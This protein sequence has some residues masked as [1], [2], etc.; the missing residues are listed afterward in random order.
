MSSNT[1]TACGNNLWYLV[2]CQP[3][4]ETYAA[5]SLRHILKLL[6]FLPESRVRSHGITRYSPFF[7]GYL[8]IN[9]DLQ[10]IPKSRINTCPG[11]LRLVEFGDS[12]QSIPQHVIDTISQQLSRL[13]GLQSQPTHNFSPGDIVQVKYGPLQDLEMIF[14]GS[15]TPGGRVCVLLKL[16]GRL[17]EVQVD[18]DM[19]EKASE[20]STVS[21]ELGAQRERYTRGKGNHSSLLG[22]DGQSW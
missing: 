17:K 7:S 4:K 21:Q 5:N 19:L 15:M 12:P 9:T 6:V 20:K 13:N 1:E 10:R 16:L 8:F 14:V 2:H 11:V 18:V 22:G 3:R